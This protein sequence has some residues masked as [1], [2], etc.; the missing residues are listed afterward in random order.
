M[1]KRLLNLL[2]TDTGRDTSIVFIGTLMN[3]VA[4]G[5][6]FIFV[7]RLLGPANYGLFS[8][9][10]STCIMVAAIA[11]FGLD[12][13]ILRFAK[14]ENTLLGFAFKSYLLLGLATAVL[15]FIAAPYIAQLLGYIE[16]TAL[17]RI[18]FIGVIFIL[19]TNFFV[20]A[21]QSRG[22]FKKASI[23]NISSNLSRL[24]I[25]AIAYY[26]FTV[27]LT[28]L[29]ALFF[30]ITAVSV[31]IGAVYQP[32][33]FKKTTQNKKEFFKY[34]FWIASA[35][36]ISSVPF[37]SFILLKLAGPVATG[38]YAAPFKIL[39]FAYQ[40][41]GNFTR[42]LSSRYSSFDTA[43]KAIKFSKKSLAFPLVFSAGLAFLVLLAP[44]ITILFGENFGPA[45]P[46][47]RILSVGFIFFFISTIPSSII[48]YY[49]G[50]SNVSFWI[51][52]IRY[53]VFIILLITL[54]PR[55]Q[56]IGGAWAFTITEL[57]SLVLMSAYAIYKLQA[58]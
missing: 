26:F 21:L 55:L 54:V 50:K 38:L 11:N 5:L 44:F 2:Y 53:L 39:T 46:V 22:E 34:N 19:L 40:F 25:L 42:V 35:L 20:A 57:I 49:L 45:I 52:V 10:I 1:P 17:L 18:G 30:L 48:L 13:G 43:D 27:N 15:G 14:K 6:F 9:V 29:T 7:P 8:V 36:I 31:V 16:V 12:T 47:M 37:D 24:L 56:A 51:T 32:I 41:G 33:S 23:V 4:G 58:K 28:F 3:V